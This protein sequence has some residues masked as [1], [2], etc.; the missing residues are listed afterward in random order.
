MQVEHD[1]VRRVLVRE[2]EPGVAAHRDERLEA[3]LAGDLLHRARELGVVL[4][5][6]DGP[7]AVVERLAVVRDV[8]RQEQRGVEL[9]HRLGRQVAVRRRR[10]Y[11]R[12]VRPLR[13]RRVRRG[14]VEREGRALAGRRLDPDLAAEE[15]AISRLIERP[16]PVPP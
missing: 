11:R 4:D 10:Q 15:H 9:L 2:R 8:A 3:V 16:R 13:R 6:E 7:V 1:R 5:D 14:Q 12:H